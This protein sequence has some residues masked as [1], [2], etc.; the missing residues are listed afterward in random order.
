MSISITTC[1]NNEFSSHWEDFISRHHLQDRAAI[2][3]LA[4]LPQFSNIQNALIAGLNITDELIS[5]LQ[6]NPK[7][8]QIISSFDTAGPIHL[9]NALVLRQL[10]AF[11]RLGCPV[12]IPLVDAEAV[13]V[14]GLSPVDAVKM[15]E[16]SMIPVIKKAGFEDADVYVRSKVPGIV[17]YMAQLSGAIRKDEQ[18]RI[19]GHELDFSKLFANLY[20]AADLLRPQLEG[21]AAHTLVVYGIDEAPHM[22]VVNQI[23]IENNLKPVSGLFSPLIPGLVPGKKMSKSLVGQGANISLNQDPSE[24]RNTLLAYSPDGPETC[25]I[26]RLREYFLMK[27]IGCETLCSLECSGCKTRSADAIPVFLAQT[28]EFL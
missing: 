4:D 19:Y 3:K 25:M 21:S 14:R 12:R 11:L 10:K 5:T 26:L 28:R 7:N 8:V 15:A 1:W 2:S 9:G 22:N 18:E 17:N 23:A 6:N 27:A 16:E 24:A 13:A 20:M